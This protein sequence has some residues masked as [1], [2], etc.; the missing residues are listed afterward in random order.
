MAE[1]EEEEVPDQLLFLEELYVSRCKDTQEEPTR[2]EFFR[3]SSKLKNKVFGQSMILRSIHIGSAAANTIAKFSRNRTDLR[4]IDVYCN[5]LKDQGLG[6]LAHFIQLNKGIQTLNIGCNDI[7]DKSANH[8]A[9][10]ILSNHLLSL[11]LG[12]T[13]KA[14]HANTITPATLS[15]LVDAIIKSTNF[16]TLGVSGCDFTMHPE[17]TF[18]PVESI[19]I[20][21]LS[22]SSSLKFLSANNIDS[23]KKKLADVRPILSTDF[24]TNGLG[25]NST[26]IRLDLSSNYLNASPKPEYQF[27]VAFADYLLN[28]TKKKN[29][30]EQGDYP[31]LF[32]IDLSDNCFMPEVAFK[33]AK[34]IEQTKYLGYLDLSDN[35]VGDDGAEA[36]AHA[37]EINQTIVE[38]HL[39]N[40]QITTKGGVALVNALYKNEVL[41][42]LN[43]SQNKLGDETALALATVLSSNK[44][45]SSLN[46]STAMITDKGGRAIAEASIL[47]PSLISLEMCNNFFL[48]QTGTVFETIFKEN[49]HILKIN[50]SGTQINHFSFNALNEICARNNETLKRKKK[51]PARNTY[52]QMQYASAELKRKN[53]ILEELI[54]ENTNKKDKIKTIEEKTISILDAESNETSTLHK[55]IVE[56]EQNLEFEK[57]EF[58][59]KNETI[60]AQLMEL[61]E[62]E[63][64]LKADLD[65]NKKAT[66]KVRNQ[67]GEAKQK[68]ETIQQKNT[69]KKQKMKEEVDFLEEEVK[70]LEEMIKTG[71][72]DKLEELPDFIVFSEG[73]MEKKVVKKKTTSSGKIPNVNSQTSVGSEASKSSEK[74]KSKKRDSTASPPKKKKSVSSKD[75]DD[76]SEA[77]KSSKKSK[78]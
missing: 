58:A 63:K 28:P 31:H 64:K 66:E 32:Y 20:K 51:Q 56:K 5:S 42:T 36:I 59:S 6:I 17:S 46:L 76:A 13:E 49:R 2:E 23:E 35:V 40:C 47:C 41:A 69:E 65:E 73:K 4:K 77:S 44:T 33:F 53:E 71:E 27:G 75:G 19:L 62:K 22:Q 67:I 15:I 21:L 45:I 3:F 39:R 68:L 54:K 29:S 10:M 55:Q 1:T 24:I 78:K 72:I 70:K 37:L 14:V 34:F 74:K 12:I 61:R 48:E 11:Q 25:Y 52:L 7:S 16:Q 9:N 8:M 57:T 18:Q 38:L 60:E 30:N 43:L 26:L 50:V